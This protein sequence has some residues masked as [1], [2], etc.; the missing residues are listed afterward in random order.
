MNPLFYIFIGAV[1]A[2]LILFL[3]YILIS[4]EMRRLKN[5]KKQ[6]ERM[7][8]QQLT[9]AA[10]LLGWST[11]VSIIAIVIS[12]V[13][14]AAG[15]T[16][17]G[18]ESGEADIMHAHG[19]SYSSD[20]SKIFL[21]AHDGPRIY[22][23]GQWKRPAGERHDY[24]GF[25][26]VDDGFYS[27]GHPVQGSSKKN[28]FGII[29]SKDEGKTF[30]TLALYGKIDFHGMSVGFKSHAIY[31][32]NS[33]PNEKMDSIGLYYSTDDAKTWTK[34]QLVGL[35]GQPQ[36]LAVH[37]TEESVIAVGTNKGVYVSK[38]YGQRFEK[39]GVDSQ[40]T[41]LYFNTDGILW[42]GGA[43]LTRID[44]STKQ[45]ENSNL[46]EVD[47]GEIIAF[48]A[49]NPVNSLEMALMTSKNNIYVSSNAGK[50]WQEIA[51]QGKGISSQK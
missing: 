24:M 42:A 14:W 38:D 10:T 2:F 16:N 51:I 32:F 33:E 36:N 27:S 28:P 43:Y 25:S 1:I 45:T 50:S 5:A 31:V 20:G 21:A 11:V 15:V 3:T 48:F 6:E 17:N 37:P 47:N 26:M 30:E 18:S 13:A 8:R 12:G 23:N 40:V 49:Q 22:E 39:I 34:S 44:L 19:M 9:K 29:K 35:E 41:S 4:K 46:P 7:R